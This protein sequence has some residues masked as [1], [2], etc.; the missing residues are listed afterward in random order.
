M[1]TWDRMCPIL[2]SPL[3]R[4][5]SRRRCVRPK[6]NY[7]PYLMGG[8]TASPSSPASFIRDEDAMPDLFSPHSVR[9]TCLLLRGKKVR[10]PTRSRSWIWRGLSSV[11]RSDSIEQVGGNRFPKN[12]KKE[13]KVGPCMN[14]RPR[15]DADPVMTSLTDGF[16]FQLRPQK[17]VFAKRSLRVWRNAELKYGRTDG[18]A[19]GAS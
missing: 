18:A 19:F 15:P 14:D 1:F 12:K 13:N 4:C 9:T 6:E 17:L 16:F 10:P 5:I 2:S 3:R 11:G 7:F 8:R